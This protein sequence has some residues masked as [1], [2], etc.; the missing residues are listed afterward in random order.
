MALRGKAWVRP[1]DCARLGIFVVPITEAGWD[2]PI[3]DMSE[4]YLDPSAVEPGVMEPVTDSLENNWED[5]MS[6]LCENKAKQNI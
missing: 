6:V 4:E 1:E 2:K 5:V 3:E